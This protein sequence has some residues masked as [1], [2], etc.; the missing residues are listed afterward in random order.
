MSPHHLK[1]PSILS[2]YSNIPIHPRIPHE[3]QKERKHETVYMTKVPIN[4]ANRF[5]RKVH[6]DE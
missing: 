4:A 6:R 5:A 3:K 2:I 1:T